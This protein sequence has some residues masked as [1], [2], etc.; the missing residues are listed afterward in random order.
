MRRP[1]TGWSE[2][3]HRALLLAALAAAWALIAAS[4]AQ[5]STVTVGSPLTASFAPS[6]GVSPSTHANQVLPEPG[7]NAVSPISGTIVRWRVTQTLGGPLELR[8]LTPTSDPDTYTGAGTSSP[9]T[10]PSTETQTFSTDLPIQPGQLIGIDNENK[11]PELGAATV[12]GAGDIGWFAPIGDGETRPISGGGVDEELG[13]N[14]D[15]RPLPGITSVSPSSGPATGGTQVTITGHDF[16]GTTAVRFDSVA[17]ASFTVNS[18]SQITAVSPPASPGT[19][20]ISIQN[21]GLSPVDATDKFTF[22]EKFT[23]NAVCVVPKLRGK[24]L[25]RARK[26]LRRADCRLGKV[27]PTGQRTGKVRKQRPEAGRVLPAGG[28]VNVKLG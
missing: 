5:A 9:Q 24:K 23:S 14:A 18:D 25:K 7:A 6:P 21:P 17:A 4:S 28:K 19:V 16:T 1:S 26:V 27:K 2:Q 22:A 12:T 13:F 3:R 10:A 8:V 11:T 20:D 15:V